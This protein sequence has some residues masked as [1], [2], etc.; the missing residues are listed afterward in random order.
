MDYKLNVGFLWLETP[1]YLINCLANLSQNVERVVLLYTNG[2]LPEDVIKT[3]SSL[4]EVK[5]LI[6]IDAT[7]MTTEEV[8]K[9]LALNEVRALIVCGW[10]SKKWM[11]VA[12]RYSGIKILTF[13]NQ[14]KGSI[15]QLFGMLYGKFVLSQI[16]DGAFVPGSR[17]KIFAEKIG[18][19]NSHVVE[20]LY[21]GNKSL[22]IPGTSE[23]KRDFLFSGRLVVE[24]NIQSL[25]DGY[26]TYR[27]QVIDP[28]NLKIA[29]QGPLEAILSNYEGVNY[30]GQ[31]SQTKLSIEMR[32]ARFLVL[33]SLSERWGVVVQES[34]LSGTPVICSANCGSADYFVHDN[35]SGFI[36]KSLDSKS[37]SESFIK[38]HH[39][40]TQDYISMCELSVELA[41]QFTLE[42]WTKSLLE[43]IKMNL[44]KKV[45]SSFKHANEPF[46]KMFLT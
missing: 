12:H 45:A 17:S 10:H 3:N 38:A 27:E 20:G 11:S 41:N 21:V 46:N 2:N 33:P 15:R 24:K 28:W 31:L 44:T 9:V 1:G 43:L 18:F 34:V 39:Q 36:L 23:V 14:W 32:N 42:T 6:L 4:L 7:E 35:K 40:Q 13:D 8:H 37:I 29:G 16:F 22:F 25:L 30:V 26:K 5:K 19:S